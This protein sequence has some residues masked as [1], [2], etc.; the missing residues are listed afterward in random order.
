MQNSTQT[1]SVR[2]KC[3]ECSN[4]MDATIQNSGGLAGKCYYCKSI[5]FS[6]QHSP[7]EKLIRIVKNF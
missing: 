3:P 6:K 5:I 1:N 7:K 2:I 4:Y